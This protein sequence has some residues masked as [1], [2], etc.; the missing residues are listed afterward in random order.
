MHAGA[1]GSTNVIVLRRLHQL[2]FRLD[3]QTI[4]P[5]VEVSQVR[6]RP[7]PLPGSPSVAERPSPAQTQLQVEDA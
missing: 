6:Q 2:T 1:H 4:T 7:L 3:P 5:G